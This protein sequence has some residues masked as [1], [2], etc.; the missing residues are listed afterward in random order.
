M[1][2]IDLVVTVLVTAY[3]A[4][5][6]IGAALFPFRFGQEQLLEYLYPQPVP[7]EWMTT[8]GSPLYWML[9]LAMI[10]VTPAAAY[11]AERATR[12]AVP[13]ISRPA[14]P[15]WLPIALAA[16]M[17]TFCVYKLA[18]AEA[19]SVHELWDRTYCF[20]GRVHRRVE[21]FDLLGMKYYA[22]VYS[23]LPIVGC[24]LLA[25]GVTQKDRTA[26]YGFAGVSAAVFWFDIATM[27]KAPVILYIATVGLTLGLSGFG[28]L[29][30]ALA[31]VAVALLVFVGLTT[32][33]YC[34]AET[35]PWERIRP[36]DAGAA[37]TVIAPPARVPEPTDASVSGQPPLVAQQA[38]KPLVSEAFSM[39]RAVLLRMAAGF[40][41][42]VQIFAD[43][44]ERCG[45]HIPPRRLFSHQTCFGPIKVFDKMHPRLAYTVGF[46]PAPV[47]ASAH[48]EA[49]P[50]Y[51]V[52]AM[53]ASGLVLGIL[54][55]FARG[56]DSLS[57]AMTVA[58]CVYAYYLTQ[59][60]F[61]GSLLDSYGLIWLISPLLLIIVIGAVRGRLRG[62]GAG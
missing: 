15:T 40:P 3:V 47:N 10:V 56:R 11:A 58:G 38:R 25:R 41:Y 8:L 33:Q 12:R 54:A 22:V 50:W 2:P 42:Y 45:A 49:G 21:L 20:R 35:P 6:G 46:Q 52:T 14:I 53:A 26:L 7:L 31:A 62:A 29:R 30:S 61:A 28:V 55:A 4:T 51:A 48:A 13:T 57:I 9:L 36:S 17:A 44:N 27:M 59:S 23:S 5:T 37:D 1:R 39:V 60:S 34:A 18:E 16:A 19:L 43:P 24:Y 32:A